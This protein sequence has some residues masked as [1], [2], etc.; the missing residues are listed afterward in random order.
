MLLTNVLGR[1]PCCGVDDWLFCILCTCVYMCLYVSN[2]HVP[3]AF[4]T[5]CWSK[6]CDIFPLLVIITYKDSSH[7]ILNRICLTKK[8]DQQLNN[9]FGTII[10]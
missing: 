8:P 2:M 9:A 3:V 5:I 10:N 7:V 1:L 4:K 6:C